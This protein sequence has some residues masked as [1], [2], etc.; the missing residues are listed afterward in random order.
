MLFCVNIVMIVKQLLFLLKIVTVVGLKH[1][2][3]VCDT[4]N[5][6]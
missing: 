5:M 6:Y 3:V 4:V 1:D 2:F